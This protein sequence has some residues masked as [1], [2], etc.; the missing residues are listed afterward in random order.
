M[1][2]N[3]DKIKNAIT[4]FLLIS[5]VLKPDK[6]NHDIQA[7]SSRLLDKFEKC[8]AAGFNLNS[9]AKFDSPTRKPI[10]QALLTVKDERDFQENGLDGLIK[11]CKVWISKK[12]S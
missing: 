1:Q 12:V 10:G 6:I 11:V 9:L 4:G 2:E 7:I 5:R 8:K 3:R